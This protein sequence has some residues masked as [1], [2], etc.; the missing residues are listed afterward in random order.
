MVQDNPK[1]VSLYQ[2]AKAGLSSLVYQTATI[3]LGFVVMLL[4]TGGAPPSFL[5]A[6]SFCSGTAFIA[7]SEQR[8]IK[9]LR[10]PTA[11]SIS[12][13]N[14]SEE[15]KSAT[16][17]VYRVQ[18]AAYGL[19]DE[20]EELK[21]AMDAVQDAAYRAALDALYAKISNESFQELERIALEAA[22]EAAVLK[23]VALEAVHEES[24]QQDNPIND[25]LLDSIAKF[26]ANAANF[27]FQQQQKVRQ[28]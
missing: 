1:Q 6:L 22:R 13:E 8:R 3:F 19:I 7:W 5:V 12:K 9:Q 23:L 11:T 16:D 2:E 10:S 25:T 4:M 28:D 26:A 20:S 27:V 21:S 17:A 24:R 14:T 15:F 18:N